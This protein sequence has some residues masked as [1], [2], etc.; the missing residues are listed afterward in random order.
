[1][2][3]SGQFHTPAALHPKKKLL[4]PNGQEFVWAPDPVWTFRSKEK[5]LVSTGNR[6]QT[7]QLV[8]EIL[9]LL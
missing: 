9:Y 7:V 1:M 8:T 6:T 2:E 3:V 4:V 5:R